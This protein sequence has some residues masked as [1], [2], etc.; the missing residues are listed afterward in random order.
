MIEMFREMVLIYIFS[1]DWGKGIPTK[2]G[3]D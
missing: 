1:V 3:Q 2:G